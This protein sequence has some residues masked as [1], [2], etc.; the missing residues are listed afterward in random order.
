MYA[1]SGPT[2]AASSPT[3]APTNAIHLSSTGGASSAFF[4]GLHGESPAAFKK[5]IHAPHLCGPYQAPRP[6][7]PHPLFVRDEAA[8]CRS[9]NGRSVGD[10]P[11]LAGGE[12]E[13]VE[14]PTASFKNET[15]VAGDE[16]EPKPLCVYCD[17]DGVLVDFNKG[18][19]E[20]FPEGGPIAEKIPTHTVT[21]LTYEE[22]SEMWRRVETKPDFFASLDWMPDGEELWRWIDWNIV[23]APAVLTGLPVGRVGQMAS[24]QKEQWCHKRLGKHVTVFCCGTRNKQKFS[25][26]R[27]VLIDDRGDLREAWEARGGIFVHHL[28]ASDTIRQLREVLQAYPQSGG[29]S[30]GGVPRPLSLTSVCWAAQTP[31]GCFRKGCRYLHVPIS[32]RHR[33]W[34]QLWGFTWWSRRMFDELGSLVECVR[35]VYSPGYEAAYDPHGDIDMDVQSH[36]AFKR[37]FD[38]L[39]ESCELGLPFD[40]LRDSGRTASLRRPGDASL[41]PPLPRQASKALAIVSRAARSTTLVGKNARPVVVGSMGLAVEVDG[42]DLDLTLCC[43]LEIEPL[44]ALRALCTVL[45]E[46]AAAGAAGI[47][48]VRLVEQANVPVASFRI[49]SMSV[50]VT[51]NQ[52]SSIRDTLLLRYALRSSGPDLAAL[53]RLLKFWLQQRQLP[54]TKQGGFPMLVWMRQAIRFFQEQHVDGCGRRVASDLLRRF[55]AFA[56]RGLPTGG[57]PLTI[58]GEQAESCADRLARGVPAATLLLIVHEVRTLLALPPSVLQGSA[59]GSEWQPAEACAH[60][61]PIGNWNG[62]LAIFYGR[63][64]EDGPAE[65]L[66][67]RVDRVFG[68]PPSDIRKDDV[69]GQEGHVE[70]VSRRGRDWLLAARRVCDLG[71]LRVRAALQSVG[72]QKKKRHGCVEEAFAES[73]ETGPS[74]SSAASDESAQQ[75]LLLQPCHLVMRLDPSAD[76][77][78]ELEAMRRLVAELVWLPPPESFSAR[79]CRN[80]MLTLRRTPPSANAS[81]QGDNGVSGERAVSAELPTTACTEAGAEPRWTFLPYADVYAR[82]PG[83]EALEEARARTE[84]LD[85]LSRVQGYHGLR[86]AITAEAA[87]IHLDDPHDMAVLREAEERYAAL[88]PLGSSAAPSEVLTEAG[89]VQDAPM[90]DRDE[91]WWQVPEVAEAGEPEAAVAAAVTIERTAREALKDGQDGRLNTSS[92]LP[93]QPRNCWSEFEEEEEQFRIVDSEKPSADESGEGDGGPVMG[94]VADT[95]L[96]KTDNLSSLAVIESGFNAEEVVELLLRRVEKGDILGIACDTDPDNEKL[97]RIASL[98]NQGILGQ[99]NEKEAEAEG[100]VIAEGSRIAA[101]NGVSGDVVKMRRELLKGH[102]VLRVLPAANPALPVDTAGRRIASLPSYGLHG[103]SSA[104]NL[105]RCRCGANCKCGLLDAVGLAKR[106]DVEGRSRGNPALR[107]G[108]LSPHVEERDLYAFFTAVVPVATVRVVRDITTFHSEL[109]GFVNF[110]SFHDAELALKML[111]GRPLRGCR[112][113][114]SWSQQAYGAPDGPVRGARQGVFAGEALPRPAER[115]TS[116]AW[117][118]AQ[119]AVA[120]ASAPPQSQTPQPSEEQEEPRPPLRQRRPAHAAPAEPSAGRWHGTGSVWSGWGGSSG[121]AWDNWH[122]TGWYAHDNGGWGATTSV[123]STARSGFANGATAAWQS[124]DLRGGSGCTGAGD[125]GNQGGSHSVDDDDDAAWEVVGWGSASGFSREGSGRGGASGRGRSDW[126]RTAGGN[127]SQQSQGRGGGRGRSF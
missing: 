49:A 20:L 45:K 43:P 66:L 90:C 5:G 57:A 119:A 70:Y 23:P 122:G 92:L 34:I 107:I 8:P 115:P 68:G 17:L 51:V 102:V 109:H 127:T 114:L 37:M 56:C 32:Y 113:E 65:L 94:H 86:K 98:S 13:A 7:G 88:G 72:I 18:C 82:I 55:L 62:R 112:C 99:R 26:S 100:Q 80:V 38:T 118:L 93:V 111:D 117:P 104:K 29:E 84:A 9:R 106:L 22:E 48:D 30:G 16:E 12:R 14:P 110:R 47:S 83:R 50:D 44:S 87:F 71:R 105:P 35:A 108:R 3:S 124:S 41:L 101:V 24:K 36:G 95:T 54:G 126:E 61:C 67:C 25:G 116:R 40:F 76:G 91:E 81:A 64:T 123:S 42:S 60:V 21:K 39:S 79:F 73:G 46:A 19:L 6:Q 89:G 59:A 97:L 77:A 75:V 121:G 28:C 125:G 78:A 10:E 15:N 1:P 74:S 2:L 85:W 103:F 120:E 27:C 52:M 11:Q 53:L 96:A 58:Q 33:S 69:D 31:A 63:P 4:G